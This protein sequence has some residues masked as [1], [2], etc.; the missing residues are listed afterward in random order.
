[1]TIENLFD[2]DYVVEIVSVKSGHAI[3]EIKHMFI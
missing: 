3:W 1:M 2:L